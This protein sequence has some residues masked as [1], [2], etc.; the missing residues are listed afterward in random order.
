MIIINEKN[1]N[2]VSKFN[3]LQDN[4]KEFL[5]NGLFVTEG[6][7]VTIELLKSDL[8]LDCIFATPEFYQEH[9]DLIYYRFRDKSRR[10]V[11]E[12]AIIDNVV[13]YKMRQGIVATAFIPEPSMIEDISDRVIVL[14]SIVSSENV[15]SIIRNALAFG[16][17]SIIYD[18]AT[19]S[20]WLSRS[21][22]VSMGS[23]FKA[24]FFPSN[25]LPDFLI[26]LISMGYVIIGVENLK[27]AIALENFNFPEQH[28]LVFGNESHGI[29]PEILEV[30]DYIIKIPINLIFCAIIFLFQ[31][32]LIFPINL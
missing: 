3:N 26:S 25:F 22:R 13:G 18:G 9:Q 27:E 15:G 30:C 31:F 28:V 4:R 19:S 14:N 5:K 21:V 16:Y 7:M 32:Y 24:K 20:P 6:E 17:D 12:K 10:F 29:H 11:A 2:K 8:E 1:K 23:L